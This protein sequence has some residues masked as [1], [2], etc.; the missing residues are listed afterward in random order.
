MQGLDERGDERKWRERLENVWVNDKTQNL[1]YL[2]GVVNPKSN[3]LVWPLVHLFLKN[4]PFRSRL[5]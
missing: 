5:L 3:D 2:R 1:I 4:V